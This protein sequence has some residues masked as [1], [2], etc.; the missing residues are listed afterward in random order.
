MTKIIP[1]RDLKNTS[2]IANMVKESDEPIYVTKNGYSEMVMM[3]PNV[4]EKIVAKSEIYSM[5]LEAERNLAEGNVRSMDDVMSDI[6]E[7]YDI[8]D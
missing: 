7:R 3:N 1:I 5:L 6:R 4:Y 2:G 8:Q